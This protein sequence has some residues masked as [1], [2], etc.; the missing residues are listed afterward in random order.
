MA[1]KSPENGG[2]K[3]GISGGNLTNKIVDKSILIKTERLYIR[4]FIESDY[5][6][7]KGLLCLYPGWLMQKDNVRGFF[8]WHL[9]NY[10]KM[11][12]IHGYVCL[13]VFEKKTNKLIGNIGLNEHDDLYLPELGYGILEAYR[14]MGYAKEAAKAT[15][16]W[17]KEYFY[18]PFLVGTAAVDNIASRKVLEYCGFSFQEVKRIKVHITNELYDFAIYRYVF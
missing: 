12:I 4:P 3:W 10:K 5:E 17:V 16:M 15:L 1:V 2:R 14:G 9:S 11:D 7:F 18:I 6:Q 13:G 8:E